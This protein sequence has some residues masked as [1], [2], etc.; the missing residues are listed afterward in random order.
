LDTPGVYAGLLGWYLW[1]IVY[2]KSSIGE[3]VTDFAIRIVICSNSISQYK[4][5]NTKTSHNCYAE[6]QIG[7]IIL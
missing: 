7:L 6:H 4:Q 1:D 5:P 2:L 3:R